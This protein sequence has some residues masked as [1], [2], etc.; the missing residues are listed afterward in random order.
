VTD[1]SNMMT[2]FLYFFH[3]HLEMRR[4]KEAAE[5]ALYWARSEGDWSALAEHLRLGGLLTPEMRGFVADVL[6]CKIGKPRGTVSAAKKNRHFAQRARAVVAE[7]ERGKSKTAAIQVVA[8]SL[9]VDEKTVRRSWDTL[10][11]DSGNAYF[12][13]IEKELERAVVASVGLAT[14]E[15]LALGKTSAILA[16]VFTKP[17]RYIGARATQEHLGISTELNW[18]PVLDR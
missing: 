15:M 16:G 9:G 4:R 14:E 2:S 13:I 7:M 17:R 3:R 10:K 18:T 12:A 1:Q 11:N 6:D 8:N 5:D